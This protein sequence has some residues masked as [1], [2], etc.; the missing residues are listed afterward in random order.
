MNQYRNV[1]LGPS[2]LVRNT[3][4]LNSKQFL[5]KEGDTC[6]F[7]TVG[8]DLDSPSPRSAR[9]TKAPEKKQLKQK[10]LSGG[11]WWYSPTRRVKPNLHVVKSTAMTRHGRNATNSA[12]YT[13]HERKKDAAASGYGT[14]RMRLNKDAIKGFDCCSLT[15]QPCRNPV[16]TPEGWL[17]DKEAVIKYIL[18]KKAEYQKK[19]VAF[20]AQRDREFA[21]LQAQAKKDEEQ[22]K[23]EFE[24]N[25]SNICKNSSSPS[26]SSGSSSSTSKAKLPSFWVPNLTP[27]A[28]ETKLERPHKG[29]FCPM[30]GKSLRMKDLIEV[31]F[32]LVDPESKEKKG[33]AS[34]EE[35]YRC[36]VTNDVLRNSLALCVLKPTGDVVTQDCVDRIIRKDMTHPLTGQSLQEN[37]IIILQ[38]GGTGY[39]AAND[40]LESSHY[41]PNLAI[42]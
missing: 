19:L 22:Q 33:F 35:R 30:S 38:R 28:K 42:S 21:E 7:A 3:K 32:T 31:K 1:A 39:S 26:S 20:E 5:A 24:K 13:Y 12:V 14:E 17:F 11:D 36:P 41:R 15:L 25:E 9:S 8:I 2:E 6:G 29:V 4:K 16:V 18:E 10:Q 40:Q 37:D 27:N 23:K 34:L